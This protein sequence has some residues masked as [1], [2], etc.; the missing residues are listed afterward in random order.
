[1]RNEEEVMTVSMSIWY[2][3]KNWVNSRLHDNKLIY[4]GATVSYHF[5]SAPPIK[6]TSQS[7]V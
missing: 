5:Q 7:G 2:D 6:Y 3:D 1:M 4:K